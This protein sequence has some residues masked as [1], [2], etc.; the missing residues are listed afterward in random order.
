MAVR[1]FDR[2]LL[3]AP[4]PVVAGRLHAIIRAQRLVPARLILPRVVVEIAESGRQAVAAMLQR[5]SA[6]RPQRILQ[7][8][9]QCHKA[10]T[11]E[12]DMGVLPTRE[13]EAEVIEPVIERHTVDADAVIAHVVKSD[14]PSRL[15]EC[16]CRKMTSRSAPLSARQLRIR[17]SKVRRIPTLISGWWRRISSI[18]DYN[19]V[20]PH[21]Q[22]G[23]RSPRECILSLPVACPA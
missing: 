13:G 5:G 2:R 8:L 14:N 4:G 19:T 9:R 10:L 22:L 11:T 20:Q 21:F 17:R 1:A 18:E 7:T 23:Y 16:S 6:E 12:H 15:G 3:V